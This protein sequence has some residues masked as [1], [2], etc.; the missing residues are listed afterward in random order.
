[1]CD[2]DHFKT[3]N[4]TFGHAGGDD[5]LRAFGARL[6]EVLRGKVDW[7]ARI[8]GEEFAIVLPEINCDSARE[9]ARKL[10]AFVAHTPFNAQGK[11]LKVTAS[12]GVC[13]VDLVPPDDTMTAERMLKAADAALYRSKHDGRN[14]VTSIRGVADVS[15]AP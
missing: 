14:R 5:I 1:L 2:I 4:D 9:V 12:F 11:L 15:K 8:G 10:R 6:Q 3:I 7:V 13:G